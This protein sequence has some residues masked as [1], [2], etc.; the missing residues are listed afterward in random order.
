LVLSHIEIE[1]SRI[2]QETSLKIESIKALQYES[3]QIIL[4]KAE[5]V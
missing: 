5:Q 3:V 2:K 4:A 1:E